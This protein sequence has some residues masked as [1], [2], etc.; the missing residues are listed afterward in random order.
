MTLES[1]SF[2]FTV[3]YCW[4][5]HGVVR[6]MQILIHSAAYSFLYS[7]FFLSNF[8]TLKSFV[9][10]FSGTVR[11]RRLKLGAHMDSGWMYRVYQDQAAAAYLSFYFF[12]FLSHFQTLNFSSHFSQEI[13]GLDWNLV[14]MWTV[15]RCIMHTGVPVYLVPTVSCPRGQDTTWYLVPGDK[16]PRGIL[17]LGTLYPGVECTPLAYLSP[18]YCRHGILS[19][20]TLYPGVKCPP[21]PN[22]SF[23]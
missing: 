20:G 12:I 10:L 6:Q 9:T 23:I 15:G 14:Q 16:I 1:K 2:F 3:F 13:W 7:F 4:L 18:R 5:T 8:Q 22:S 17:S 11:P 21:Q 19:P